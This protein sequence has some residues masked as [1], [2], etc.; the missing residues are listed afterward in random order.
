MKYEEEHGNDVSGVGSGGGWWKRRVITPF[1]LHSFRFETTMDA[2][3][4]SASHPAAAAVVVVVVVV[5]A[6]FS[7][8]L[9]DS[10][11]FSWILLDSPGWPGI[12]DGFAVMNASTRLKKPSFR[13]RLFADCCVMDRR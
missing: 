9:L 8:I 5:V 2:S 4:S 6:G 7:W 10:P 13:C 11:G 1:L 12:L 3:S